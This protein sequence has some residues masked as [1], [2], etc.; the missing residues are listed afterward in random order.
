MGSTVSVAPK[1]V[2]RDA[3]FA[4]HPTPFYDTPMPWESRIASPAR[5]TLVITALMIG[6]LIVSTALAAWYSRSHRERLVDWTI[7]PFQLQVPAHHHAE[8]SEV[9]GAEVVAFFTRADT[10]ASNRLY[11]L[12]S[13]T[14]QLPIEVNDRLNLP[15]GW[16]DQQ[17]YQVGPAHVLQS[18]SQIVRKSEG[19]IQYYTQVQAVLT[20]DASHYLAILTEQP[21]PPS[22]NQ[23]DALRRITRTFVDT[24]YQTIDADHVTLN[25]VRCPIPQ[26]AHAFK[27][28]DESIVHVAPASG[29][30][31]FRLRIDVPDIPADLAD[32]SPDQLREEL[33]QRQLRSAWGDTPPENARESI[34][35]EGRTIEVGHLMGVTGRKRY[36]L[37]AVPIDGGRLLTIQVICDARSY[38]L[39]SKTAG[40]IATRSQADT[41]GNES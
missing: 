28:N 20:V 2:N 10:I 30:A 3:A 14:V 33:I 36:D 32:L 24:R 23:I 4:A 1:P 19:A 40:W 7:G 9:D 35:I 41:P 29:N 26:G 31:F 21:G 38:P 12:R 15:R 11:S 5:R 6:L 16:T 34:R 18:A 13:P 17:A 27:S 25:G 39:A 22:S 8:H 37:W